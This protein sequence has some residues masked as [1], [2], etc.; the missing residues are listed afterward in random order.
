MPRFSTASES[1]LATCDPRLQSVLR[2]AIEVVDFSVLEG[3]RS[4]ARQQLLYAQGRTKPGS[5]VTKVDGVRVKGKHNYAPSRAVDVLPYP[6]NGWNDYDG[7]AFVAGHI[8]MAAHTLGIAVKWGGN[9]N[10][11]LVDLPHFEV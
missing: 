8:L 6:F 10:S 9:W 4:V 2:L 11:D 1:R 5:I 7:F 3:H